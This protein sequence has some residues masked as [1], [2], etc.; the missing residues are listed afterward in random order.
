M[1]QYY[2]TLNLQKHYH[3][4]SIILNN[5]NKLYIFMNV[6]TMFTYKFHFNT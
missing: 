5:D 4:V 3:I 1:P 2:M 6:S